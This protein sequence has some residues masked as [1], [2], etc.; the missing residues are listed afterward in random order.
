[1]E[2][3]LRS[4]SLVV[5]APETLPSREMFAA[6]RIRTDKQLE[7]DGTKSD[8][9][10]WEHHVEA[11]SKASPDNKAWAEELLQGLQEQRGAKADVKHT[12]L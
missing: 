9:G 10:C 7:T 11:F 2:G 8:D 4:T 3:E 5:L 12:E 6:F 1:M